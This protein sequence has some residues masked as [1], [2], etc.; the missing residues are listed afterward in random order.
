MT[1][2]LAKST[3]LHV[4]LHGQ[5]MTLWRRQAYRT[6]LSRK[7]K[8]RYIVSAYFTRKE[9]LPLALQSTMLF[10]RPNVY[11]YKFLLETFLQQAIRLGI[12]LLIP[13]RTRDVVPILPISQHL[14]NVSYG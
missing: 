4:P 1:L 14:V 11:F 10:Q 9:I 5:P 3:L 7:T 12:S 2:S 13:Q 6:S 8:R